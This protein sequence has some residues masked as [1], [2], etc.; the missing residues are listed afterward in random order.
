LLPRSIFGFGFF[1][2][3]L[4]KIL[5]ITSL[6]TVVSL[7]GAVHETMIHEPNVYS[8]KLPNEIVNGFVSG[9]AK[10]VGRFFNA[11]VELI[12]NESQGVYGKAQAE[13]ILRNFF[14]NN[15]SPN[16]KFNY[17]PLH[18]SERDN[19]QYYIGELHTGKGLYRVTIYMKD[20]LIH[21]MRIESND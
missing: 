5:I 19:A 21:R 3:F 13:Q 17:K 8:S 6:C 11:S 12:F 18:G 9:D 4:K 15:A 14:S 16:G 10:V 7:R 2:M 20:R 1:K